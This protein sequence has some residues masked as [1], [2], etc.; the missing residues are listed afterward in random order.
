MRGSALICDLLPASKHQR[1]STAID[2]VAWHGRGDNS[3]RGN[4][5]W[6]GEGGGGPGG[7]IQRV[8]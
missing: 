8:Y 2:L 4:A 3:M 7:W 1:F 5:V 6:G